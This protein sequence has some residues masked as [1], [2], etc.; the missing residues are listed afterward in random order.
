MIKAQYETMNGPAAGDKLY[1]DLTKYI[2][3]SIFGNELY[4]LG[5]E[6]NSF[7][8]AAKDVLPDLKMMG[9]VSMGNKERLAGQSLAF[10]Q[11]MAAGKMQGQDLN[12]LINAGFNPLLVLAEKHGVKQEHYR[13]LM[14][15]GKFTSDMLLE[16]YKTATGPGGKFYGMLDKIAQ[17]PYGKRE[18]QS[19][20]IDNAKLTLGTALLPVESKLLDAFQPMI[21][22]LPGFVDRI[23]PGVERLIAGFQDL[24]PAMQTFG[25]SL[26]GVVK[27]VAEFAL[28][29]S[30]KAL[31]TNIFEASAKIGDLLIPILNKL[32]PYA[33]VAVSATSGA[34]GVVGA[35]AGGLG[36][37]PGAIRTAWDEWFGDK[38]KR[39][40]VKGAL[41]EGSSAS[42]AMPMGATMSAMIAGHVKGVSGVGF[43]G[44][45]KAEKDGG[46]KEADE[47]ADNIVKGGQ[48]VTNFNFKNFIEHQDNHFDNVKDGEAFTENTVKTILYRIVKGIPS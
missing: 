4:K 31:S 13:D 45:G 16:A 14:S 34:V 46:S 29:D 7:G 1:G 22:K 15:D 10:S 18:A 26:G 17:T 11:I 28:S 6:L 36:G 25:S 35:V 9:D 48:R 30:V 47:A 42:A 32:E 23:E 33:E 24:L 37:V 38:G 39:D 43:V 20:N 21:D 12:Q 5:T 41:G 3:D 40:A 19:G 27:P 8:V 44:P 2:Q